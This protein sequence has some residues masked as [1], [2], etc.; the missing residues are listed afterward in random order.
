[1]LSISPE[2]IT[3]LGI[4]GLAGAA[5]ISLFFLL[6]HQEALSIEGGYS[7]HA[8]DLGG[9]TMYGVTAA[10]AR[11][12]GYN[13]PMAQLPES[14]AVRISHDVYWR[15][16]QLDSIAVIGPEYHDLAKTIYYVAF[17]QGPHRSVRH[18]QVCLNISNNAGRH[19]RDVRVDG[20]MGPR[21]LSAFAGYVKRRGAA[22]A[23]TLEM[24]VV[25]LQVARYAYISQRRQRNQSFT[26]GWIKTARRL[27]DE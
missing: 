14:T 4:G 19:Y 2:N 10:V 5:V 23:A 21:T 8:N 7:N 1:M 9:E 15:P 17:N 25:G 20:R 26:H 11:Q 13:G 18:L 3:Q 22:G 6:A 16:L 27:L 24:C 12:H